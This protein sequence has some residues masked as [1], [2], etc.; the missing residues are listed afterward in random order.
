[1]NAA[2]EWLEAELQKI[3]LEGRDDLFTHL[4]QQ[5]IPMWFGAVLRGRPIDDEVTWL[6]QRRG[7]NPAE[8]EKLRKLAAFFNDNTQEIQRRFGLA[9][10]EMLANLR[11]DGWMV[12][13][14]NDYRLGGA[15]HTFW[16]F[17]K[18]EWAVKGEGQTDYEAL[19]QVVKRVEDGPHTV[20][21]P[22]DLELEKK[23]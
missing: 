12:A 10:L 8:Q 16:L 21:L 20:Q 3:D 15:L 5:E 6:I 19:A 2:V 23:A 4:L 22:L 14:H 7:F 9:T 13:V 11:R 17:T 18:G 1:M